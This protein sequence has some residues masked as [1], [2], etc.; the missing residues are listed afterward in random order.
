M[1][2]VLEPNELLYFAGRAAILVVA[3]L[4]FAV[5]FASWRR[6]VTREFR[7]LHE[8]LDLARSEMLAAAVTSETHLER[9]A[10]RL[11]G[12]ENRL[13][14]RSQLT[15]AAASSPRGYELALRLAR[16]GSNV[17][18]IAESSGVTR[19]EAQLMVRLHGP[20]CSA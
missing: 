3:L 8:A 1:H 4:A 6:V 19:H 14:T 5:A 7:S 12:L 2:L 20:R 17:E 15:A 9:L 13:D 10:E 18:E 11:G 16:N